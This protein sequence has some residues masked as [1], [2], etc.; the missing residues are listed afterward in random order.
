M[1]EIDELSKLELE[2][3]PPLRPMLLDDLYQSEIG[4]AH[5]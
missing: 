1:N 4:R 2:G 3:L 5:V